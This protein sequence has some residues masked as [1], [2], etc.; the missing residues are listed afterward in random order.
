M[1][2]SQTHKEQQPKTHILKPADDLVFQNIWRTSILADW[3]CVRLESI[4]GLMFKATRF[5]NT[6]GPVMPEDHYHIAPLERMDRDEIFGLI[7]RKRYFILHAPR[8]TGKT[9]ALLALMDELNRAGRHRAVYV[10]VE[11]AQ[12]AREDVPAAMRAMLS[13]L[14]SSAA[15]YLDD[16]FVEHNW[17]GILEASGAHDALR[18]VLRRWSESD[19]RPLVLM[20]DEVDALV[21]DTL[22]SVLRQL[23]SGYTQRPEHFP[24]CVILCGIRDVRDYRIHSGR[25]KS[26]ITG[27]SA[28]NIKAVSLRMGDFGEA[29]VRALLL[30][31]TGETGQS[32]SEE[33]LEEVWNSTS[34]QPWLVNAL[35]AEALKKAEDL[36]STIGR[37]DVIDARE[38]LI[39]R[40]DTHLDQLAD[41]LREDR[42]K[43]VV[44]PIVSG[45]QPGA[46][47]A[48]D[49]QYCVDLGLIRAVP[50]IAVANAIYREVIPRELI[51]FSDRALSHQTAWYVEDGRLMMGRLM[52]AFQGF[53]REH[54]EHWVG[55]FD[56]QEAGAQLLLQAFLQRVVNSGGRIEREYGLGRGRTDLMIEW[57]P[58]RQRE[59]VECKLRRKSLE[60]TIAEGLEQLG[61]YMQRCG[62]ASGHLVVFDRSEKRSWDEKVFRREESADGRKVTVWGM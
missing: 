25:D 7:E 33:A 26:I 4:A 13:V 30:Q 27:G 47:Q 39:L 35:A 57:G 8:Q 18:E 9:S 61:A 28:F 51:N 6:A 43:R 15:V 31:H 45:G 37:E 3:F 2:L 40:R 49:V 36:G 12:S 16:A 17:Q 29:E 46:Y 58:R 38:E 11:G 1:Q 22:I 42:V 20:I 32:W 19:P 44:E 41:K 34:G 21:G 48:D 14:S 10:N 54:S 55:R 52:E 50:E 56:Y 23:R 53:F 59:A 24:Q 5:F 60:R 62:T